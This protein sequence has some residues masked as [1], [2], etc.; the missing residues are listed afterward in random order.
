MNTSLASKRGSVQDRAKMLAATRQFFAKRDVLEVDT[1]ILSKTAPIDA[2]IDVMQVDM[3]QNQIGF[4]H[5]SPEY[6]L[7]KLLA[8]GSGD[9][10][11]LGH[12]FRADEEGPL[13][14]PEFTM[15]EWYRIGMPFEDFIEETLDLIRLFL[16]D[17]KADTFSYREAFSKYAGLDYL[18]DL[19]YHTSQF[20]DQAK[21]WD[22]DTQL[23]LLFTHLIEPKLQDLTV[24]Y[25]YPASQAALA[26]TALKDGIPIARRFEVYY[27]G[28]ELAN[29][30]DELGDAEEMRNRLEKE[31]AKRIAL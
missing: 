3:G 6:E 23:N 4:L 7:K 20:S 1:N 2:H 10:Y 16:G 24:I 26:K 11:Q 31:N 9:I 12:V 18:Q 13:H 21:N 8:N 5:T 17:L 25:N 27:K 28:I 15:L 29:G 22:R 30:F 19:T 14:M